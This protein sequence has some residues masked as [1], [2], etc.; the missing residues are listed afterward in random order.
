MLPQLE[1]YVAVGAML[2]VWTLLCAVA[3]Y[4]AGVARARP[5][6]DLYA[7]ALAALRDRTAVAFS[8]PDPLARRAYAQAV[9]LEAV[10]RA[11]HFAPLSAPPA[12]DGDGLAEEGLDDPAATQPATMT[13]PPAD[14][15][16]HSDALAEVLQGIA[17]QTGA[18]Q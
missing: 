15:M 14:A 11:Q 13:G 7:L 2:S 1:A 18:D 3:G 12:A 17:L 8:A 9:G 4:V 5:N 16:I 10:E 6:S